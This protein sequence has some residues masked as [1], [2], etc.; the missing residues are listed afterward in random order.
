MNKLTYKYK[1]KLYFLMAIYGD[2][3]TAEEI[4]KGGNL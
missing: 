1:A 2:N 3:A 4:R